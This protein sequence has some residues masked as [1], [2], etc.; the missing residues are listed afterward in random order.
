VILGSL[1][2]RGSPIHQ[3]AQLQLT[4]LRPRGSK[5]PTT[6]SV[7]YERDSRL[8]PFVRRRFA[9][10]D[11]IPGQSFGINR[12]LGFIQTP[13]KLTD[14]TLIRFRY[15]FEN[16]KLFNLQNIPITEATRNEPAIRLGMLSAGITRETRDNIL[17]STRGQLFSAD[18]SFASNALGGNESFN[19]FFGQYQHYNTPSWLGR[20]TIRLAA[21]IGPDG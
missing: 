4:D 5:W 9:N 6:F 12:L 21:R 1:R 20:P 17:W 7:F 10:G 14:R 13:R 3:L 18:Y 19:K 16:A 11:V 8:R 2:L 15:S